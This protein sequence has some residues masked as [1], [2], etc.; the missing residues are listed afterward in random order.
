MGI[1]SKIEISPFEQMVYAQP[2]ICSGEWLRQ[3]PQGL[4]H[5]NGLPN[6]GQTTK[7]YQQKI[8]LVKIVDFAVQADH[9]VKLKESEKNN[10]YFY[11]A[12]ELK[13]KNCWIWN[14]RWYQL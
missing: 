13:I 11:L 3:T 1:V 4:W 5:T 2:D 7:A 12:R 10:K 14:W 6:L 8:K 9:R